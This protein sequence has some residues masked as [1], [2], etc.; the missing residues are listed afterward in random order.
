M[1]DAGLRFGLDIKIM[2][3]LRVEMAYRR[4]A[5]DNK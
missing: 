2:E 1:C 5:L 3:I 4:H